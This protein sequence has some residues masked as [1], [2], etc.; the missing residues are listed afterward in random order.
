MLMVHVEPYPVP[1]RVLPGT[2]CKCE[3]VG[4]YSTSEV[5]DL[6]QNS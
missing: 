2:L 3:I 4:A 5:L 6:V 1:P